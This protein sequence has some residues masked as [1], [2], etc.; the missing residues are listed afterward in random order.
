MVVEL[1]KTK[2][3]TIA[4]T[5]EFWSDRTGETIT[6][7]DAREIIENVTGFFRVLSEWDED[8][9]NIINKSKQGA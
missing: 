1:K 2:L 3:D 5:V 8:Q 7:E 6:V 9:K 4:K